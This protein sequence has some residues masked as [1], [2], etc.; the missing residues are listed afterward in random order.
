[1]PAIFFFSDFLF[2]STRV[3][4]LQFAI[5]V[6]SMVLPMPV[7][8][9]L[10]YHAPSFSQIL[11]DMQSHVKELEDQYKD[12]SQLEE[13]REKVKTLKRELVWAHVRDKRH[14]RR[15]KRLIIEK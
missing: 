3:L 12:I 1:M 2:F 13:I 6:Y 11:P 14:V 15:Q 10:F 5:F 4:R 8:C 7:F 9:I